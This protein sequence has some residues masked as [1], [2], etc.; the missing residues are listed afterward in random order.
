MYI[1]V[2]NIAYLLVVLFVM[3]YFLS[4]NTAVRDFIQRHGTLFDFFVMGA[5]ITVVFVMAYLPM[6][7]S[8]LF[9]AL[10]TT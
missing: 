4:K 2:E 10:S 6:I 8:Y 9:T 5:S 1:A 3:A 7:L